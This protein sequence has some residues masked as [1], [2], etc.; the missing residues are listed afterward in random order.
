MELTPNHPT[1]NTRDDGGKETVNLPVPF[2]TIKMAGCLLAA[3][4]HK[5]VGEWA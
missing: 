2:V 3:T 1:T 5:T 4:Q